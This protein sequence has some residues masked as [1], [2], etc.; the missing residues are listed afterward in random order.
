MSDEKIAREN[1]FV[2]VTISGHQF[3]EEVTGEVLAVGKTVETFDDRDGLWCS[4]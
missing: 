2:R 4:E 3:H 1:D